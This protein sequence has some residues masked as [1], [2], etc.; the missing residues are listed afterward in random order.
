MRFRSVHAKIDWI[1]IGIFINAANRGDGCGDG[2]GDGCG[3]GCGNR[4]G[5]RCGRWIKREC[6][7]WIVAA[8]LV[9]ISLL[10]LTTCR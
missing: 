2:Y 9:F 4:C 10:H 1:E 3:D 8:I 6:T 5:D 7:S